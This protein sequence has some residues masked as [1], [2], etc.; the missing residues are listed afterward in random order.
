VQLT[1]EVTVQLTAEVTVQLTTEVTVQLR[2]EVTVQLTAEVTVQLTLKLM[3][4]NHTAR[5]LQQQPFLGFSKCTPTSNYT[6]KMLY[7]LC[8]ILSD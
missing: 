4:V 1:A 5:V 8:Y 2:A 6:D 3:A 7:S